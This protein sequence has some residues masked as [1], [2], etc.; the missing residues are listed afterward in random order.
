MMAEEKHLVSPEQGKDQLNLGVFGGGRLGGGVGARVRRRYMLK[1]IG[2]SQPNNGKCSKSLFMN[3][4]FGH[5]TSY[6]G[7]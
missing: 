5:D 1:S 3:H 7:W 6:T 4:L 2:S